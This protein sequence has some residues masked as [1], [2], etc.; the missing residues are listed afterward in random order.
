[1]NVENQKNIKEMYDPVQIYE[2]VR[3]MYKNDDGS[4]VE[5]SPTQVEIFAT[6]SMKL[7]PR[8]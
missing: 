4:P 5:L 2:L 6:I 1:M 3:S 8:S 7:H